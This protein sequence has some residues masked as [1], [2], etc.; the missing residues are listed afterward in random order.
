ME[1]AVAVLFVEEVSTAVVAAA[2]TVVEALGVGHGRVAEGQCCG[3]LE[4][5]HYHHQWD[6]DLEASDRQGVVDHIVVE[7][8]DHV[9][10]VSLMDSQLGYQVNGWVEDRVDG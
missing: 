8:A 5:S 10:L 9:G 4:A 1:L 2:Y 3:S 6:L 7:V